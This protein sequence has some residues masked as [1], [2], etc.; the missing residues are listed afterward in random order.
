MAGHISLAELKM[1]RAAMR[2]ERED[3]YRTTEAF[4]IELE[5]AIDEYIKENIDT[6]EEYLHD[7]IATMDLMRLDQGD[8]LDFAED[9]RDYA[10]GKIAQLISDDVAANNC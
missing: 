8:K 4:R 2:G 9:L 7:A 1:E 6:Y 3:R 5:I 10:R